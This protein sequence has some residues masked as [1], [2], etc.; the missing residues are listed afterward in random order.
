VPNISKTVEDRGSIPSN[1]T[2]IY[3]MVYEMVYDESNGH[4]T[5]DVT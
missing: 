1:G 5:G 2:P 3:E 4:V